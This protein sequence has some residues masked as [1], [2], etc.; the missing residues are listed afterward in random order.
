MDIK[1]A[2]TNIR[3][4]LGGSLLTS[5]LSMGKALAPTLGKTLDLSVLAGLASEG[6]SQ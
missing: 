6:A 2:S 1:L 5:T 3:K 4:Q